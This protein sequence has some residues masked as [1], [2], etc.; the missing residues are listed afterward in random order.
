M[1]GREAFE[2]VVGALESAEAAGDASAD[3]SA[4]ERALAPVARKAR[5]GSIVVLFSDLLDL[6]E[7]ALGAFS[8]LGTGGRS[9]VVVQVLDPTELDL[10]YVGQVRLR[11]LEGGAVVE[12]DADA[13]RVEYKARLDALTASWSKE[14]AARGGR[15]VRASTATDPAEVLRSIVRA[16]GEARR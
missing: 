13:V 7:R 16:I 10:G 9:L 2:R 14:L 4:M 3:A 5:R 1:A 15:L 6:P 11:A 12:T 8:A